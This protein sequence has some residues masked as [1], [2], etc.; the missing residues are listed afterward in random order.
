MV[1][2]AAIAVTVVTYMTVVTL[3]IHRLLS[4]V[5]GCGFIYTANPCGNNGTVAGNKTIHC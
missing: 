4:E 5:G 3:L 2:A 1:V